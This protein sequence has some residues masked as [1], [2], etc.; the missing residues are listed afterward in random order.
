MIHLDAL[1]FLSEAGTLT[2]S[3]RESTERGSSATRGR[4]V[5]MTLPNGKEIIATTLTYSRDGSGFFVRPLDSDASAT[6]VFITQ[7]GIRNIRFL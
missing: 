4:R 2:A 7:S 1:F 3:E 6:R 5:A